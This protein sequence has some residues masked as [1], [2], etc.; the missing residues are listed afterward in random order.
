MTRWVWRAVV[1]G[2][3]RGSLQ[4]CPVPAAPADRGAPDRGNPDGNLVR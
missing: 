3:G 4:L 2:L 1:V